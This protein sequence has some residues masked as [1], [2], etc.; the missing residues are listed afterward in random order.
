[1]RVGE[2]EKGEKGSWHL[3]WVGVLKC[4]YREYRVRPITVVGSTHN[5]IAAERLGE[6]IWNMQMPQNGTR[7]SF[8]LVRSVVEKSSQWRSDSASAAT[9]TSRICERP[10]GS[11]K[12]RLTYP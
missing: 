8:E 3:F 6:L 1:M 5:E 4:K 2:A 9:L 10:N 11:F 7:F 12:T